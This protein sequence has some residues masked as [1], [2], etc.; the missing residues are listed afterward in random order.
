MS[1]FIYQKNFIN[2]PKMG[3]SLKLNQKNFHFESALLKKQLNKDPEQDAKVYYFEWKNT[4]ENVAYSSGM[5]LLSNIQKHSN[6]GLGKLNNKFDEENKS[7]IKSS[8]MS[9]QLKRVKKKECPI[10]NESWDKIKNNLQIELETQTKESE[11]SK[12]SEMS[13]ISKCEGQQLKK[14]NFQ[15]TFNTNSGKNLITE[16]MNIAKKTKS[17]EA[18]IRPKN[19][20]K[21]KQSNSSKYENS[22]FKTIDQEDLVRFIES[23]FQETP[24][25]NDFNGTDSFINHIKK[26]FGNGLNDK[27]RFKH[28]NFLSLKIV[29]SQFLTKERINKNHLKKLTSFEKLIFQ[30]FLIRFGYVQKGRQFKLTVQNLE[31]L[32]NLTNLRIKTEKQ[33]L[34]YSLKQ[35]FK[36]VMYPFFNKKRNSKFLMDMRMIHLTRAECLKLFGHYFQKT[37]QKN[38]NLNEFI[39]SEGTLKSSESMIKYISKLVRSTEM[40]E[41]IGNY[42]GWY[43]KEKMKYKDFGNIYKRQRYEIADKINKRINNYEIILN[44]FHGD[45]ERKRVFHWM[46]IILRDLRLNPKLKIPWSLPEL[47]ESLKLLKKYMDNANVNNNINY[48]QASDQSESK[49]TN[50]IEKDC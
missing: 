43:S 27:N 48:I 35:I 2:N 21:T 29:W 36:R 26:K 20:N 31:K 37:L 49:M 4:P 16:K 23:T 30:S 1:S 32:Q 28:F 34:S 22:F 41:V 12:M 6:F 13:E 19:K 38:E 44:Q 24:K 3:N 40:V 7:T 17:D 15:T 9:L 47:K 25:F 46:G 50:L 10:K 18:F 11:R 33:M 14:R 8:E 45:K 39:I 42:L 5:K